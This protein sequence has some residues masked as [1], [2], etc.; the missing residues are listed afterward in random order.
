MRMSG[1][2]QYTLDGSLVS[3]FVSV[4]EAVV[5]TGVARSSISDCTNGL[6]KHAGGFFWMKYDETEPE[7]KLPTKLEYHEEYP[8][9]AIED[10]WERLGMAIAVQAVLDYKEALERDDKEAI[11][12]IEDYFYSDLFL[13]TGLNPELMIQNI[14]HLH[15]KENNTHEFEGSIQISEFFK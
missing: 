4:R 15:K 12:E 14:K 6:L 13:A 11:E 2:A 5:K 3:T 7:E 8:E 9:F 1:I 10:A